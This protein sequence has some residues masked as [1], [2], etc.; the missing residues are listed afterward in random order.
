VGFCTLNCCLNTLLKVARYLVGYHAGKVMCD[1]SLS[2]RF[3]AVAALPLGEAF[4]IAA[5]DAGSP[6]KR[7]FSSCGGSVSE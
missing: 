5:S 1:Y 3:P 4:A 6:I 2:G 7:G